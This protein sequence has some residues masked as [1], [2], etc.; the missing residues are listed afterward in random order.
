MSESVRNESG[1]KRLSLSIPAHLFYLLE[2][3]AERR[4]CSKTVIV[5][6]A[7]VAYLSAEGLIR[8]NELCLD[9]SEQ[10]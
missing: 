8:G 9:E 3:A 6:D 1:R 10:N 7:I 5:C 4:Y 2:K